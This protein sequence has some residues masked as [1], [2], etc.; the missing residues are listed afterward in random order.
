MKRAFAILI[1]IGI[2]SAIAVPV[3]ASSNENI[4]QPRWSYLDSVHAYLD[5][6]WLGVATCEGSATA[7]SLVEVETIVRLQQQTDTGWSTIKTWSSTGTASASAGG[8][9]AVA[10][11]YDYRVTVSGY[12]YDDNGNIVETGSSSDS[13]SY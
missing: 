6:N 13:D 11:G 9:Y 2:L 10:R 7:R 1:V 3:A 5:I 12:V 8:K 4:I